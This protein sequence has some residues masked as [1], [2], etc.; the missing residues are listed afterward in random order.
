MHAPCPLPG[1]LSASRRSRS[2]S[3]PAAGLLP[4]EGQTGAMPCFPGCIS[5]C[6]FP[7]QGDVVACA[8]SCC[9]ASSRGT[10]RSDLQLS[11]QYKDVT[12]PSSLPSLSLSL[13]RVTMISSKRKPTK[14]DAIVLLCS[15]CLLPPLSVVQEVLPHS[16]TTPVASLARRLSR[17][18]HL[19]LADFFCLAPLRYSLFYPSAQ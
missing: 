13:C 1:V 5:G 11:S 3:L 19:N 8:A 17:S 12:L 10:G 4:T 9:L 18:S 16:R 15:H 6:C 14:C 7:L 2:S